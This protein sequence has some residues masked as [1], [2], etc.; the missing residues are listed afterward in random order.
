MEDLKIANMVRRA[1]P[2][3][4]PD[5]P[6]Q[7]LAN[8]AA[9]KRGLSRSI[10]DAGWAGSSR[11]YAPKRKRLGVSGLRSTPGIRRMAAKSAGMQPPKTA[12]PKRTSSA[13]DA[14][15]A[16]KQTRWPRATSCGLD[17]PFTRKPREKKPTASSRRRSHTT[18]RLSEAPRAAGVMPGRKAARSDTVAWPGV[19][20]YDLSDPNRGSSSP[21]TLAT[22]TPPTCWHYV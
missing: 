20:I 8:G 4:D 5:K 19:S 10:S 15:I 13:G 7:Y 18:L 9:A 6:G 22:G 12:S 11:F 3:P 16:P 14:R 21:T 2:V 17:W 1:K